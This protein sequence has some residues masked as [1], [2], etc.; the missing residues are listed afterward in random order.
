[1]RKDKFILIF[2]LV[3]MILNFT[4]FFIIVNTLRALYQRD[5][6]KDPMTISNYMQL[7]DTLNNKL[8]QIPILAYISIGIAIG[9]VIMCIWN[10]IGFE[11]GR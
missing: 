3:S 1:M 7:L 9:I 10:Y 8:S 4:S 6:L 2:I 11:N 5:M